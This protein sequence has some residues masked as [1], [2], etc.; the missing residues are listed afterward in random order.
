LL[1]GTY[2]TRSL[3]VSLALLLGACAGTAMTH[4]TEHPAVNH[5][6]TANE[7]GQEHV[8]ESATGAAAARMDHRGID[9]DD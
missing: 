5:T 4:T 1:L 9:E 8:S 7:S 2:M 6:A 3:F